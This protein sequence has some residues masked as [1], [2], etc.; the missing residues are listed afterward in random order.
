[1]ISVEAEPRQAVAWAVPAVGAATLTENFE[2]P[3]LTRADR[4]GQRAPRSRAPPI[5]RELR[6]RHHCLLPLAVFS[7]VGPPPCKPLRGERSSV[8]P[9]LRVTPLLNFLRPTPL[10]PQNGVALWE[11]SRVSWGRSL[12]TCRPN[13]LIDAR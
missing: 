10:E 6:A 9:R 3:A 1:A 4:N 7:G 13:R 8:S 12:A 5:L 2:S 11:H